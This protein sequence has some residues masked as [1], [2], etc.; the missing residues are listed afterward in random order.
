MATS[1]RSRPSFTLLGKVVFLIA[2]AVLVSQILVGPAQIHGWIYKLSD[3]FRHVNTFAFAHAYL[4]TLDQP[5]PN[6]NAATFLTVIPTAMQQSVNGDP[7]SIVALV[8]V[9]VLGIWLLWGPIKGNYFWIIA[10]PFVGG[11]AAWILSNWVIQL[12]MWLVLAGSQALTALGFSNASIESKLE[13]MHLV[14]EGGEVFHS[15]DKA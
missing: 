14:T 4:A 6:P 10:I 12:L 2:A 7:W 11:V 15:T 9:W 13:A 5:Q 1:V 3:G 8:M